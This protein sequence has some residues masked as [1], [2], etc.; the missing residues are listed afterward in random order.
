MRPLLSI[1]VA[2]GTALIG[3]AI[4]WTSGT[5]LVQSMQRTFAPDALAVVGVIVGV[6]VAAA[7]I[8]SI[9]ISPVGAIVLGIVQLVASLLTML[10]PITSGLSPVAQLMFALQGVSRELSYGLGYSVPTGIGLV[11]GTILLIAGLAA[12]SRRAAPTGL[13]RVIVVVVAL[14]AGLLGLGVALAGGWGVYQSQFLYLDGVDPFSVVLALLGAVLVAVAV[15]TAR[16]SSLG[17]ILLGAV[18]I[19]LAYV[20]LGTRFMFQLPRV[21]GLQEGIDTAAAIGNAQLIGALLIGAGVA[22]WW[23]AR[24]VP[25]ASTVQA[26][27]VPA[28]VV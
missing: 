28:P 12:G 15:A 23:R 7:S 18:V 1:V 26:P 27:G 25:V 13:T 16:W 11:T 5:A 2:F 10:I 6:L 17:V 3:H 4:L 9:V 8:L 24:R 20:E 14:V 22:L 19:V 21:R